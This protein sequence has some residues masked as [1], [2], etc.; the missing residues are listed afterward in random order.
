M[1]TLAFGEDLKG[2]KVVKKLSDEDTG[3]TY[4]AVDQVG[5]RMRLRLLSDVLLAELEAQELVRRVEE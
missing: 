4:L 1:R 2:Y 3:A 5:T